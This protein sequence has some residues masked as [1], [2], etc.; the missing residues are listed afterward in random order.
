M[1][2]TKEIERFLLAIPDIKKKD[3]REQL[4]KD[5]ELPDNLKSRI[6]WDKQ[7][8]RD[9]VRHLVERLEK[10]GTFDKDDDRY[11]LDEYLKVTEEEIGGTH[12]A[13]L[14][15]LLK[16]LAAEREK[17]G[18][19]DPKF[20]NREDEIRAL[21]RKLA[22]PGY[23]IYAPAGYGKTWLMRRLRHEF[24]DQKWLVAHAT[25]GNDAPLEL[26]NSLLSSVECPRPD[27]LTEPDPKYVANLLGSKLRTLWDQDQ[28]RGLDRKYRKGIVLLIDLSVIPK[29]VC[30]WDVI[31]DDW[32]PSL[33]ANISRHTYFC[34][35]DKLR[36]IVSGRFFDPE[37]LRSLKEKGLKPYELKPFDD[38]VVAHSIEEYLPTLPDAEKTKLWSGLV[39]HVGG[40][41]KCM[42]EILKLY[43]SQGEPEPNSFFQAH[44]NEIKGLVANEVAEVLEDIPEPARQQ[45]LM[46]SPYRYL[47]VGLLRDM[48]AED[49]SIVKVEKGKDANGLLTD[50]TQTYL[51]R[52]VSAYLYKDSISRRIMTLSLRNSKCDAETSFSE[53]CERAR[54]FYRFRLHDKEDPSP[55]RWAIEILYQSLQMHANEIDSLEGRR[56][57]RRLF[58]GEDDPSSL[59]QDSMLY[60][61]LSSLVEERDAWEQLRALKRVLKGK[62]EWEFRF[63]LNYFLRDETYENRW[64]DNILS[65]KIDAFQELEQ[66]RRQA[67][68]QATCQD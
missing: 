56:E 63:T 32:L 26:S 29:E 14:D 6:V 61:C 57:L 9:F 7:P 11:A 31:L 60:E 47:S 2:L 1:S 23:A 22:L 38:Q 39:Y 19:S 64:S 30:Y 50:L 43:K 48:L 49:N 17:S 4:A 41:P 66:R 15:D 21:T 27:A 20:V 13:T 44:C 46:L 36:T 55:Y 8:E 54:D 28:D 34:H 65:A 62:D 24:D 53:R 3:F 25:L 40:H 68:K 12:K 33:L 42:S 59:P 52:P 58:W 45:L 18:G 35:K 51:V 5:A 67:E 16:K 10:W 37:R